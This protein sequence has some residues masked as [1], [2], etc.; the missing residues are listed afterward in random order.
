[1][2]MNDF[3]DAGKTNPIKPK[4][5]P[6]CRGVASGEAGS[7]PE[8]SPPRKIPSG[9]VIHEQWYIITGPADGRQVLKNK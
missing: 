5:N 6:T 3:A 2:K 8:H 9:F 7:N 1:M 4:M